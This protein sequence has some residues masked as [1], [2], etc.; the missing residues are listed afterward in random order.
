M[1]SLL[2]MALALLSW[3][4]PPPAG[5]GPTALDVVAAVES[6]LGDA[7]AKA[8]PS[9]VA[10]AREKSDNDET[11]AVRGREPARQG[12]PDRRVF[13]GRFNDT[14]PF[15]SG[16]ALSFDYGSGVVVGD[17]G[18]ILT[19]YHVV[20][21]ARALHVRAEGRQSFE[22]EIIAADPRSDLAVIVP[23]EGPG[24]SPPKLKPLALGDAS[25]LRKGAFLVALG[26]PF[27]A[28]RDGRPSASW[29]ILANVARRIDPSPEEVAR[30][31]IQLRNYPTLLQLDSKLNL[32]MSGGAVINLKG[33]LVGL[34]TAAANAAGF[35][36]QAGYAIPM[37][38]LGRNVVAAL[39]QGKEY[40]YGFLGIRLDVDQGTNRVR[41]ADP[42][43]PAA[44]GGVQFDDLIVAVGDIPVTD[45]D[46]LVVAINSIPA[47]EPVT[48]KIVR[49]NQT[50]E[51]T[52]RLA[53]LPV[54]SVVIATNRPEPWRGLRVDYTSTL[55]RAVFGPDIHE[56]MARE[57]VLV[58]EVVSGSESERAGLRTG[59]IIS[60]VE[61]RP[62]RNPR[63]FAEAAARLKG[64]VRLETDQ[65]PVTVK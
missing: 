59:Q 19:A 50:I 57:G 8:E 6:A 47:G 10:I 39:K 42:G 3:A 45:A 31:E 63:D 61:D 5:Q 60:R 64:P 30:Q 58:T 18:Q 55:P 49:R 65:G 25:K 35:D 37:D 22:A 34:T 52:V 29:G 27:N 44:Q 13:A 2:P 51:R 54:K 11:L 14:D 4:D 15:A 24:F 17:K 36:A 23:R 40:E 16:E 21:G 7:I 12:M 41:S 62:V 56:A 33:E 43:T 20:K 28:A 46:S 38:A 53:K 9:V 26:N 48:L 32:G 1:P